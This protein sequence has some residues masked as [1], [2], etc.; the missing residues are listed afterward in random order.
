MKKRDIK[1]VKKEIVKIMKKKDFTFYYKSHTDLSPTKKGTFNKLVK[2]ISKKYNTIVVL[3]SDKVLIHDM[4]TDMYEITKIDMLNREYDNIV[5]EADTVVLIQGSATK[6][7]S[8]YDALTLY[9]NFIHSN[10]SKNKV[11]FYSFFVSKD[12]LFDHCLSDLNDCENHN[13]KM[14]KKYPDF[15]E[16]RDAYKNKSLKERNLFYSYIERFMEMSRYT[17]LSKLGLTYEDEIKDFEL[18]YMG[19][20]Q[21]TNLYNEKKIDKELFNK[22]IS[23]LFMHLYHWTYESLF[24]SYINALYYELSWR[25]IKYAK[26]AKEKNI[27]KI[28]SKVDRKN[29]SIMIYE[30]LNNEGCD[31]IG[32]SVTFT[33]DELYDMIVKKGE[34]D[35]EYIDG[36]KSFAIDSEAMDSINGESNLIS[37]P[38]K[39]EGK[40]SDLENCL[41]LFEKALYNTDRKNY[42]IK[43]MDE[44]HRMFFERRSSTRY[45]FTRKCTKSFSDDL[46][47]M[48]NVHLLFLASSVCLNETIKDFARDMFTMIVT[49]SLN[50]YGNNINYDETKE[51]YN[52][53]IIDYD[54]YNEK[55]RFKMT[56]KINNEEIG[57]GGFNISIKKIQSYIKSILE[58]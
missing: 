7:F 51:N 24:G 50:E 57:T 3:N 48:K 13:Q 21:I 55:I 28:D 33:F 44:I 52:V 43:K 25:L 36:R 39:A 35:K 14:Y 12:R 23:E 18:K 56:K 15:I 11:L 2:K 32:V 10:K 17:L 6:D 22:F 49:A 47:T 38:M 29:K 58:K 27:I 40:C 46:F 53:E 9:N 31:G 8:I 42:T 54:S 19:G 34:E 20:E 16:I 26:N 41:I 45:L 37:F 5:I 30:L 4:H 1:D